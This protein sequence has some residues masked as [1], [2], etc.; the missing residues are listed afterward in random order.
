MMIFVERL[1]GTVG[2]D[3]YVFL[4]PKGDFDQKSSNNLV[5]MRPQ[6]SRIDG[7]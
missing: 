4:P 6:L 7:L 2:I 5:S 1:I 3:G